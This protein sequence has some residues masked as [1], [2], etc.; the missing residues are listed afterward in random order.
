MWSFRKRKECSLI[1]CRG[2]FHFKISHVIKTGIFP[3]GCVTL[4]LNEPINNTTPCKDESEKVHKILILKYHYIKQGVLKLWRTCL[5]VTVKVHILGKE[6]TN[7][8]E[9]QEKKDLNSILILSKIP[10]YGGTCSMFH[11]Q[12]NRL[13]HFPL[14]RPKG[15]S[16]ALIIMN[17]KCTMLS[18]IRQIEKRHYMIS[19]ICRLLSAT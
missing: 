14:Y 7:S 8:R 12:Y 13:I 18:E 19:H 16:K 4:H 9:A 2:L 15:S 10:V 17:L 11:N 6:I 3:N 1:N 5:I